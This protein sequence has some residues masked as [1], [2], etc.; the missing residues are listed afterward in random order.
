MVAGQW[1]Q[2]ALTRSLG[3]EVAGYVDG[4]QQFDVVDDAGNGVISDADV[5]R[6]F[7]DDARGEESSGAVARFRLFNGPLSAEQVQALGRLPVTAKVARSR[8]AAPQRAS[9]AVTLRHFGPQE[10]VRVRLHD[11]R[12]HDFVLATPQ[13]SVP[14]A[15]TVTVRVPAGAADGAAQLMAKGLTSGL[16]AEVTLQIT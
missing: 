7:R 3:G 11:A 16:K 5:L 10:Q 2:V 13:V 6:L 15:A 1:V 8:S 9:V 4:V 14:G 12:G